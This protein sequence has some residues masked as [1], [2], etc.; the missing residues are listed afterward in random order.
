MELI[1]PSYSFTASL[2]N[3][4][5]LL[6]KKRILIWY[7]KVGKLNSI[8]KYFLNKIQLQQKSSTN[9]VKKRLTR[10]KYIH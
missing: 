4:E 10:H 5:V 9:K 3:C 7:L 1:F 6:W 2:G 8:A